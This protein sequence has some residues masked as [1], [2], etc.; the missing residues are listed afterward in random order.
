MS[1]LAR[2]FLLCLPVALL[3]L[4]LPF[5]LPC[6]T[7]HLS[8]QPT[9]N[10]THH[11]SPQPPI[12]TSRTRRA[13]VETAVAAYGPQALPLAF[14]TRELALDDEA[15]CRAFVVGKM[16]CVLLAGDPS[17]LDT[18]ASRRALSLL[19]AQ[20]GGAGGGGGGKKG[21]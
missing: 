17:C 13:A 21:R 15:D 5:P 8:P 4:L 3:L 14:L 16:G 7:H 1:F 9:P 11:L 19:Q 12:P 2:R 10:H 20:Q 6:H 18:R